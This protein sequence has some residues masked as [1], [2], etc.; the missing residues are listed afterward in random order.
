VMVMLMEPSSPHRMELLGLQELW[1]H[2][3]LSIES[4]TETIPS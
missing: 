3:I 1:D 2:Q 4:L